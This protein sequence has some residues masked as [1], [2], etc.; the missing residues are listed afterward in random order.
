[1]RAIISPFKRE[2]YFYKLRKRKYNKDLENRNLKGDGNCFCLLNLPEEIIA[3]ILEN[4]DIRQ[5]I[6]CEIVCKSIKNII[7]DFNVY[8]RILDQK[9]K[10]QNIN[11]YMLLPPF[12]SDKMSRDECNEYYKKRLYHFVYLKLYTIW[13]EMYQFKPL[14]TTCVENRNL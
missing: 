4:L 11:N 8:Q 9:C 2:H 12:W 5:L 10:K 14:G 1:M 3:L 6:R 7:I 13:V